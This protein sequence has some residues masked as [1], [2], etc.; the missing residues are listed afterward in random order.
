MSCAK[1]VVRTRLA[2]VPVWDSV[3]SVVRSLGACVFGIYYGKGDFQWFFS[4]KHV[5]CQNI[6]MAECMMDCFCDCLYQCCLCLR[7]MDR[8]EF[9][10]PK[11]VELCVTEEE[12][13]RD[14][15]PIYLDM[16][17]TVHKYANMTP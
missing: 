8:F 3:R 10:D 5:F 16:T 1:N 13:D 9:I 15:I 11:S 7:L 14:Y 12:S 17:G 2:P 6:K 4:R